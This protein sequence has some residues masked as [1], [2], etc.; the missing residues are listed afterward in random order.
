MFDF[1]GFKKQVGGV[2]AQV[3]KLIAAIEDKRAELKRLRALPPQ[4]ADVL[5]FFDA[6]IDRR[7]ANFAAALQHSV[8]YL[9]SDPEHLN[10]QTHKGNDKIL[11]VALPNQQPTIFSLEDALLAFFQEEI[12]T[13]LRKRIEAMP[14]AHDAGPR[15]ADRPALI[16]KAERELEALEKDLATLRR[17]AVEAGI[18]ISN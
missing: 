16:E 12:K 17:E 3:D 5:E 2:R 7:A 4:Q 15:I 14:W 1:L 18:T 6:A 10:V 9:A 8:G 11:S 13:T